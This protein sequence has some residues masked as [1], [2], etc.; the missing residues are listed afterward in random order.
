MRSKNV[1]TDA[2]QSASQSLQTES[3][4][5]SAKPWGAYKTALFLTI[6]RCADYL[7]ITIH[8]FKLLYFFILPLTA[9][10]IIGTMTA[11]RAQFLQVAQSEQFAQLA[12][13][14]NANSLQTIATQDF[15]RQIILMIALIPVAGML[16][17]VSRMFS[18]PR[19]DKSIECWQSFAISAQ[20]MF[21][22]TRLSRQILGII[23]TQ[24]PIFVALA[25]FSS[26]RPIVIWCINLLCLSLAVCGT[27]IIVMY[28]RFENRN[29]INLNGWRRIFATHLCLLPFGLFFGLSL[30]DLYEMLKR[31]LPFDIESVSV[32]SALEKYFPAETIADPGSAD[33]AASALN[34]DNFANMTDSFESPAIAI[35][36]AFSGSDILGN[37]FA[38]ATSPLSLA[39]FGAIGVYGIFVCVRL[40]KI[41]RKNEQ[42]SAVSLLGRAAKTKI[43]A[44]LD[45]QFFPVCSTNFIQHIYSNKLTNFY[46]LIAA[47]AAG[48][49]L[50]GA[51]G[52]ASAGSGPSAGSV[53]R[54]DSLFVLITVALCNVPDKYLRSINLSKA[55]TRYRTIVETGYS[56]HKII[57]SAMF[58]VLLSGIPA[59]SAAFFLLIAGHVNIVSAFLLP[60]AAAMIAL[61]VDAMFAFLPQGRMFVETLNWIFFAPIF[62]FSVIVGAQ[63]AV[64]MLIIFAVL[65]VSLYVTW[66]KRLLCL[67]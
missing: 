2:A 25:V 47:A 36:K 31:I 48:F 37:I 22:V 9:A 1:N 26:C 46:V 42:F 10:E 50:S 17:Y 45:E 57:F 11:F 14:L 65:S 44:K 56:A 12:V 20:Q 64:L 16:S 15:A 18:K 38:A 62:F 8:P 60:L 5:K 39:V 32:E 24:T 40:V 21:I 61:L 66:R 7:G 4:L 67:N 34:P 53:P 63:S 33:G 13:D 19:I 43:S 51:A 54:P 27:A 55:R 52:T 41:L 35:S 6:S 49:L 30:K 23:F 28:R 58:A 29:N 59:F 3:A